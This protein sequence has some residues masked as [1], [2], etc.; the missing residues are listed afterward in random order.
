MLV[1]EQPAIG[2]LICELRQELGPS[3]EQLALQLGVVVLTVN[4]WENHHTQPSP[5]AVNQIFGRLRRL[6]KSGF[7]LL[8]KYFPDD[9]T[10]A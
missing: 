4:R 3:Q 9:S 5:L 1:P 6:G 2:N 10:T 8:D 7:K